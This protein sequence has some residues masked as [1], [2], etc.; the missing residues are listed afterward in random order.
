MASISIGIIGL[1]NV[2]KSTLFNALTRASVLAANYPFA[3]IEPNVG[4]VNVPDGRL[5]QLGE[6]S[7]SKQVV[8]ATVSFTDIAGLV[9]GAA[10]GAG[11][12]N[13]FLS[14]IRECGAVAQV[15]RVFADDNVTHV[16][17]TADPARDIDT[18]GTELCLADLAVVQ[19]RLARLA[20]ESK[21]D[22]QLATD[23][24]ALEQAIELLNRA[25]FLHGH[26]EITGALGD[27][28]LITSKPMIYV[29]NLDE[30]GL[31]DD[32]RRDEMR[33]LVAPA[34]A[35]F[36][37]A[38]VESELQDLDDA[39]KQELLSELGQKQSGL[40]ALAQ[41]SY[42]I[43]GLQS[44]Y[45][46]GEQESRAWTIRTNATAPEAAGVI[47][48]DFERGFIKAD[49]VSF[50]DFVEHDGWTGARTAGKVRLEGRDYVMQPDDVVE[51]KFNV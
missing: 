42:R 11:L 17:G 14:H 8:S 44:F 7:R 4:V 20:H 18:I 13:K 33:A 9:R 26:D 30:V 29:F 5:E 50:D 49:V 16:D 10:E 34:P 15:V 19:N 24:A 48:T 35:I 41:T 47:H 32:K 21:T 45:T 1:P 12:G 27:L 28:Q 25:E 22:P 2:G 39:G 36:L 51:F 6:V 37:S 46:S 40:N 23:K 3:T 31:A 38:Q 43:L